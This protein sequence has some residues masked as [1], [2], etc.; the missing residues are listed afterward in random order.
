MIQRLSKLSA[1]TGI[2][3]RLD[4]AGKIPK[5]LKNIINLITNVYLFQYFLD[6]F[7]FRR[8]ISNK[9]IYNS[10]A[11]KMKFPKKEIDKIY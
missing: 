1:I 9:F 4:G 2:I 10:L 5:Y 3:S 6:S 7:Q 11:E 8:L